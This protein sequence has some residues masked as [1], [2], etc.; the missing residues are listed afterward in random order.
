MGSH[1]GSR[2]GG[3]G[4]NTNQGDWR[5]SVNFDK[6]DRFFGDI[7]QV[8]NKRFELKSQTP[9]SDEAIIF[10]NNL[11]VVK[12]NPVL[13]TDNNKAVYLKDFNIRKA[14]VEYDDAP[15]T[16]IDTFAVKIN[17]K[18]FKE[19]TFQKG[20]NGYSFDKADTFDSL[21]KT[22]QAQ[23]KQRKRISVKSVIIGNNDFI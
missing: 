2:A 15:G 16:Y 22:A 8:S 17:K 13:I 10:T 5:K 18:Y 20:F 1:G 6:S 9:N 14:T 12:G 3:G 7:H 4:S 11:A 19:Y 21:F 23:E